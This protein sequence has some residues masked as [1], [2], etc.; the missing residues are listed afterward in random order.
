MSARPRLTRPLRE[1]IRQALYV[2]LAGESFDGGDLDGLNR[3]HFERALEWAESFDDDAATALP[4]PGTA[5]G[6]GGGRS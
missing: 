6:D 1:A 3:D 4:T 2:V 5:T